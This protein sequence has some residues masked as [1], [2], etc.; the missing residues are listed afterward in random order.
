MD[1]IEPEEISYERQEGVLAWRGE[2]SLIH[3]PG[4]SVPIALSSFLCCRYC[5]ITGQNKDKMRC[6]VVTGRALDPVNRQGTLRSFKRVCYSVG[7]RLDIVFPGSA[8]QLGCLLVF[9][10]TTLLLITNIELDKDH[11]RW[12]EGSRRCEFAS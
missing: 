6:L 3:F 12:A 11:G 4:V 7:Y 9:F 10:S 1:K 5:A 8:S 2:Y